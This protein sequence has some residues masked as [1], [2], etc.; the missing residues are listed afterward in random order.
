MQ[1]STKKR[2]LDLCVAAAM[3]E[4]PE[5]LAELSETITRVLREEKARLEADGQPSRI[6]LRQ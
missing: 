1:E 3:C 6:R 4:D 5:Q 2:W